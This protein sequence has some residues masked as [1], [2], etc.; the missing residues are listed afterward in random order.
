MKLAFNSRVRTYT[1]WQTA[2]AEVRRVRQI[3]ER[4]RAQGRLPTER[5]GHTVTLVSEVSC[6]MLSLIM[7]VAKG[8]ALHRPSG[9]RWMQSANLINVPS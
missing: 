8:N 5:V 4:A 9:G 3:H 6:V 7:N 2:D 1:N